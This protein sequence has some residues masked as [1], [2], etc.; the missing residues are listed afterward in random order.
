MGEKFFILMDFLIL[1]IV[2]MDIK[3]VGYKVLYKGFKF[4]FEKEREGIYC[5][6]VF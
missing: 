4:Y 2:I 5:S 3:F 6:N 1:M